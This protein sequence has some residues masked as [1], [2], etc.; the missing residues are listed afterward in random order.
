LWGRWGTREV[1]YVRD[2][3]SC[4]FDMCFARVVVS[5]EE[6]NEGKVSPDYRRLLLIV[7][8]RRLRKKK[9]KRLDEIDRP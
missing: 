5:W 2:V 9:K 6:E 4:F 1:I 3:G 8:T 7:R